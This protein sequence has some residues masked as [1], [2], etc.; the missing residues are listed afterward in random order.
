MSKRDFYEVL[1]VGREASSDEIR[2]SYRKLARQYHPDV[3]KSPDA[4]EKFKEAT[5]AYEVLRDPQKKANYDRFG[6]ADPNAAGAGFGGFGGNASDFGFGDIFDMFFGGGRRNPNAPRQGADLEYRLTLD[7]KDAVFGK[8]MDIPVPRTETCTDCHG[9]GA[10]EGTHPEVCSVCRG[11]GQAESVQN[12][13]FGRVVNKR[14]CHQCSGRGKIIREQCETCS[15][16]GQVKKRRS[17]HINI[18]PGIDEGKQ[19][20]VSGEGESGVNGGP[21]GDL[22]IAIE[23]SPHEF[24][25]RD[26]NNITCEMPITFSQAALGDEIVV[27]TLDGRASLKIP[28][29]TQSGVDFRLRGKG[30]PRLYGNGRGDQMVKVKVVTPT[31]MTD[32]QKKALREFG[33]LSGDYVSEQNNSFFDKMKR[34]FTGD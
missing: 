2:K 22:Y 34:A 5:E 30:V 9:S 25:K 27:P 10:K 1:G 28:A 19:L 4:E 18:P 8:E 24:F 11:S 23:V 32:E 17:I 20:R 7:F 3:N 29:G 21:A 14:V 13:P 16:A 31:R 33:R 12:T 15:G 6:H 26:G